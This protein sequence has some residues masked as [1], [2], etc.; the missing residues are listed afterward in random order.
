ME[1][2]RGYE[3]VLRHSSVKASRALPVAVGHPLGCLVVGHVQ[4]ELAGHGRVVLGQQ[5]S[6]GAPN[7]ARVQ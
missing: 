1:D 3:R 6:E 7:V 4:G 5:H 2:A